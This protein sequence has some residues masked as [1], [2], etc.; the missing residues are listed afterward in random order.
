MLVVLIAVHIYTKTFKRKPSSCFC[1][2]E[3]VQFKNKITLD[4]EFGIYIGLLGSNLFV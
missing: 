4:M 2:K 1:N 3:F